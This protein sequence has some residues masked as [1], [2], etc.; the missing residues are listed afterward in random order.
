MVVETVDKLLLEGEPG[1]NKALIAGLR[2]EEEAR[3]ERLVEREAAFA[4]GTGRSRGL[5]GGCK[6]E[7]KFVLRD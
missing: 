4:L 7:E 1:F 2:F 5:R 3:E 6:V